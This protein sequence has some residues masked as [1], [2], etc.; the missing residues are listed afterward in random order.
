MEVTAK[1]KF[2]ASKHK[3]EKFGANKYL[4]YLPFPEDDSVPGIVGGILSKQ[5]GVPPGRIKF[6]A[7]DY[8]KDW[9]FEIF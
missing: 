6:K 4:I 7:L 5:M 8:N 1:V 2:N 9:V 3:L